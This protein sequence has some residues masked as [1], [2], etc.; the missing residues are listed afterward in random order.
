[1]FCSTD[2][3]IIVGSKM[4]DTDGAVE[5]LTLIECLVAE[6]DELNWIHERLPRVYGKTIC[7]VGVSA[8]R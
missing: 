2:G 8:V 5:Q 1:M 6:G 4:A 3:S 7:T